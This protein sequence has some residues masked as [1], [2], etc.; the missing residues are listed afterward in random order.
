M[1]L[2]R[3]TFQAIKREISLNDLTNELK[4]DQFTGYCTFSRNNSDIIMV[5]RNGS[6]LLASYDDLEGGTALNRIIDL[7]NDR[8]DA[9]LSSLSDMQ[10]KLAL[11]FNS[12]ARVRKTPAHREHAPVP[13]VPP[14]HPGTHEKAARVAPG[15]PRHRD[16]PEVKKPEITEDLQ[17]PPE[18]GGVA[19]AANI[20][21]DS[22]ARSDQTDIASEDEYSSLY[23]E[24]EALDSMDIDSMT[25]KIRNN[26]LV[27]IEKLHLEHLIEPKKRRRGE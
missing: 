20:Q 7:G 8:F 26:C 25:Q 13:P 1:Q 27:M 24:L 2:P 15:G 9:V 4:K 17:L 10:V 19:A 6:L 22:P 23:K 21:E 14:V 5:F 3:G 12:N 11:E 16:I 18:N